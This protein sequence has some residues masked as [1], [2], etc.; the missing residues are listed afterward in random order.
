VLKFKYGGQSKDEFLIEAKERL[1]ESINYWRE[2]HNACREDY[3]FFHKEG[4]QWEENLRK[5]RNRIC[6]NK[7]IKSLKNHD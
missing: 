3:L 5:D 2:N 7:K 1:H 6:Y 4:A